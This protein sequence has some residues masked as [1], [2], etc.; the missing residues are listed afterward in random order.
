MG[1]IFD[2]RFFQKPI[3]AP[4]SSTVVQ[5]ASWILDIL[6]PGGPWR[7]KAD[8][9]G[10]RRPTLRGVWGGEAPPRT[11]R[12]VW[13]GG[14]PPT[15]GAICN[16][17]I[18]NPVRWSSITSPASSLKGRCNLLTREDSYIRQSTIQKCFTKILSC[19]VG[20]RCRALG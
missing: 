6:I 10:G 18:W 15:K 9:Y 19:C 12:G 5:H 7:P 8:I 2:C 20:Y 3:W 16:S 17:E 14:S 1:S 4:N 13:G 11:P